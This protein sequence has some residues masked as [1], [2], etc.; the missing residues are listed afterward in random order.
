MFMTN[1]VSGNPI[2]WPTVDLTVVRTSEGDDNP[3]KFSGTLV[4]KKFKQ[5]TSM[6]D[7]NFEKLVQRITTYEV[8][9]QEIDPLT[10]LQPTRYIRYVGGSWTIHRTDPKTNTEK[11]VL[12]IKTSKNEPVW[13]ISTEQIYSVKDFSRENINSLFAS[14]S[15]NEKPML[16]GFINYNQV[17]GRTPFF[18]PDLLVVNYHRICLELATQCYYLTCN[19]ETGTTKGPASDFSPIAQF[20][21]MN[22]DE[23]SELDLSSKT[24]FNQQQMLMDLPALSQAQRYLI[25]LDSLEVYAK[26]NALKP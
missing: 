8:V 17:I 12:N 9:S 24:W 19:Q 3:K 18:V 21:T 25:Y 26:R 6:T 4:C 16:E 20:Q 1:T 22:L 15:E 2:Y 23:S 14:L 11:L 7:K 5:V 10:T 13:V